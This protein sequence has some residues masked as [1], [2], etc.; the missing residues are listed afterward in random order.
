MFSLP[1]PPACMA[2]NVKGLKVTQYS[3]EEVEEEEE[4]VMRAV[5]IVYA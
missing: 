1:H 3:V 5:D 2:E 4:D